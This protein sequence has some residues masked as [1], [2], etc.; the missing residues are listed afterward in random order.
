MR[1]YYQAQ[2]IVAAGE[3]DALQRALCRPLP[4]SCRVNAAACGG[5]RGVAA[6]LQRARVAFGAYPDRG[7]T[8][9]SATSSATSVP[10]GGATLGDETGGLA[11]LG[12][13]DWLGACEIPWYRPAGHAW[14]MRRSVQ[15]LRRAAKAKTK[16][17]TIGAG[18]ATDGS[19]AAARAH[20]FLVAESAAGRISRQE[21]VSMLP[22]QLLDVRPGHAVL[23]MCAAP[24][25]K[26]LQ[27]LEAVRAHGAGGGGDG[28][29]DGLL[30]ANDG[31]ARR[32]RVLAHRLQQ[33]GAG[34]CFA[35]TCGDAARMAP[36]PGM[37]GRS[38]SSR[39]GDVGGSFLG[40]DR[41]LC[42][43]PCSG[44]GTLRKAPGAW[45]SWRVGA[46]LSFHSLQLSILLRGAALLRSGG[47]LAFSTCSMNPVENEAV[48]AEA[49]R[50]AGGALELLPTDG[51]LPGLKRRP[52]LATWRVAWQRSDRALARARARGRGTGGD[53]GGGE[54]GE[55]DGA[56]VDEVG[57]LEF[58]DSARVVPESL[59]ARLVPS[60]F[61]PP[62]GGD[63]ARVLA[64][65]VRVCPHDQ[66]S[67]AFFVAL[68]RKRHALP[69]PM[70]P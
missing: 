18:V 10:C 70:A 53:E 50:R 25:S 67:G 44:D 28:G 1:T 57:S 37:Y 40:F 35:V 52:G 17:E 26:S 64:R 6:L 12:T 4:C 62:P 60:M 66:D 3:W 55:E 49:L 65:C 27:L 31:D 45:R 48:V 43:A 22:V 34:Q 24:G 13:S 23:D 51:L 59:R 58:F 41:V 15:Q 20:C 5:A 16:A 14:Q 36:L 47:V 8:G 9:T 33:A 2:G 11:T 54:S 69:L 19:G 29:G 61:P 56:G 30:V 7:G 68:I 42:D 39:D 46:A 63:V 21:T 38:S 32:A